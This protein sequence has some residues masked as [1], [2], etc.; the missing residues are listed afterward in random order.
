MP[1]ARHDPEADSPEFSTLSAEVHVYL[2][3]GSMALKMVLCLITT[4][5]F[6]A[7]ILGSNK[8]VSILPSVIFMAAASVAFAY[9]FRDWVYTGQKPF[10]TLSNR[11][12]RFKDHPLLPWQRV[13]GVTFIETKTRGFVTTSAILSLRQGPSV[14]FGHIPLGAGFNARERGISTPFVVIPL[15]NNSLSPLAQ[16][17]FLKRF[18]CHFHAIGC[19]P[20]AS[21]TLPEQVVLPPD[22]IRSLPM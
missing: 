9:F 5:A 8:S 16:A 17:N 4:T 19:P 18:F 22:R 14:Y 2:R 7:L 1:E 20:S 21:S 11:G 13:V 12:V 3:R 6:L 15:D 10:Y